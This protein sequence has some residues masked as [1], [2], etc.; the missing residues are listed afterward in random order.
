SGARPAARTRARAGQGRSSDE[1]V[2]SWR[3]SCPGRPVGRLAVS[4]SWA[5]LSLLG[6]GSGPA[7]AV[8]LVRCVAE[9]A[10]DPVVE[11]RAARLHG[12]VRVDELPDD[13]PVRGHLED[14]PVAALADERV[15]VGQPLGARD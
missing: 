12:E 13:F 8:D 5:S 3:S 9:R 10:E 14:A 1:D 6:A 15:A 4:R 7:G 11:P 2:A